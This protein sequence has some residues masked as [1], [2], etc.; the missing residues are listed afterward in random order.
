MD[1]NQK[2]I[3]DMLV[4]KTTGQAVGISDTPEQMATNSEPLEEDLK[5]P[6]KPGQGKQDK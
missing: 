3:T 6:D 4:K 2:L 5:N 1:H